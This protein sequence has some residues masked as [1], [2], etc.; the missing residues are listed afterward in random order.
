MLRDPAGKELKAEWKTLKPTEVEV[1][2]QLQ[3]AQPGAMTLL[4][5]QYG[6]SQP[7]SLPLRAFSDVGHFDGFAIHAGDTEGILK[8]SRLDEVTSL[9]IGNVAFVPG[10]L[11]TRHGVDELP[12]M[13]QDTQG[14]STLNADHAIAA[15]VTLTDGRVLRVPV[16]V[17]PPRP[18][19]LLI[20]RSVQ[21]SPFNG[22]G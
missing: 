22:V 10:E 15:K 11:S 17:G 2:L 1:N 4:V 8:G 5:A 7:Q 12:M 9:S 21:S 19:V 16:S 18:R 13:A 14:A 20:A 6:G 3:E